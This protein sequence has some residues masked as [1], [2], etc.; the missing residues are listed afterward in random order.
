[1]R[2]IT[3]QIEAQLVI[4]VED[5]FARIWLEAIIRQFGGLAIDHVQVHA[6]QGDGTAVAISLHHN[7]DPSNKVPS[8]CF[9]DGDS[10]QKTS[11]E[12][13]IY[14]LPGQSPEAY[15]FDEVMASWGEFGGKLAVALLQRF[16][17]SEHVK[18]LCETVRLTNLDTHL[19]FAQVGE[20]LGLLPEATVAAA[21]ANIWAQAHPDKVETILGPIQTKLP[22]EGAK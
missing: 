7:R 21:F 9:I 2:A 13:H 20:R 12:N 4:F 14:R 5:T 15:V 17:N 19:L 16:E 6:M 22:K 10:E 3:G 8:V 1:L 18:G 11:D